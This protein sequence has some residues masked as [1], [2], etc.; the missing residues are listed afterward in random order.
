VGRA[1]RPPEAEQKQSDANQGALASMCTPN[2][3]GVAGGQRYDHGNT[4]EEKRRKEEGFFQEEGFPE[5]ESGFQ[6][7]AGPR[8]GEA[9]QQDEGFERRSR[10]QR[11]PERVAVFDIQSS[12]L[13][14]RRS[15]FETGSSR[16]R[17]Q[18]LRER[19]PSSAITFL[20]QLRNLSRTLPN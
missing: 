9:E 13:R 11:H 17:G 5:E 7:D 16:S 20:A 14:I 3:F 4:Q 10:L 8:G 19:A 1:K 18:T 2:S 12:A 15:A 6:E